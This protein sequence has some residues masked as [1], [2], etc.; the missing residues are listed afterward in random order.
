[1]AVMTGIG[2]L[3]ALSIVGTYLCTRPMIAA[4]RALRVKAAVLEVIPGSTALSL[5]E[6]HAGGLLKEA[7]AASPS[8]R[9]SRAHSLLAA[10]DDGRRL[11]GVGVPARGQGFQDTIALIY[12][13]S[14]ACSCLSGLTILE[15]RETPGLGDRVETDARFRARFVG[16]VLHLAPDRRGLLE[17]IRSV[18]AGRSGIKYDIEAISG[19]TISSRA[20]TRIVSESAAR[21]IPVII[22]NRDRLAASG[23]PRSGGR[24]Q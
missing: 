23:P 18:A 17:H 2:T 13:Y 12:G 20:V 21:M 8:G 14:F 7:P 22:Q 15:S 5:F 9:A 4:A 19:A 1:M 24:T 10:Y 16:L 6:V 11:I 3:C